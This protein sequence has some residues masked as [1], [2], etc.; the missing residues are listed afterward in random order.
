MPGGL[1]GIP[2]RWEG[3]KDVNQL[4]LSDPQLSRRQSARPLEPSGPLT[5]KSLAIN[6]HAYMYVRINTSNCNGL[7]DCSMQLQVERGTA[8]RC[9]PVAHLFRFGGLQ[10]MYPSVPMQAIVPSGGSSAV[11]RLLAWFDDV[12]SHPCIHVSM[13]KA[14]R[15][16]RW[17]RVARYSEKK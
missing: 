13:C 12:G 16:A 5:Y 11:P 7:H 8:G 14:K 9:H 17:R 10:S 2:M 4:L 3:G 1:G 6:T 15:G